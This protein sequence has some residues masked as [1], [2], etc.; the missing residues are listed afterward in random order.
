MTGER[1]TPDRR[2]FQQGSA[3]LSRCTWIPAKHKHQLF[4]LPNAASTECGIVLEHPDSLCDED[5]PLLR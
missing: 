2:R 4:R 3:D 1:G 5:I